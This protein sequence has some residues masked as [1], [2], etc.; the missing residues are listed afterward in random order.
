[1]VKKNKFETPDNH[2]NKIGVGTNSLT[3]RVVAA[4]GT[5]LPANTS[6]AAS[7]SIQSSSKSA[8]PSSAG[9]RHTSSSYKT[10]MY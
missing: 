8:P 6:A 1:M 10:S 2:E 5:I 3:N 7:A 4:N 9:S